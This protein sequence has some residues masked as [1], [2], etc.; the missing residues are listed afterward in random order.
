[1]SVVNKEIKELAA[2]K[3]KNENALNELWGQ[4]K[5]VL[6]PLNED[7]SL[8]TAIVGG[9]VNDEDIPLLRD[10]QVSIVGSTDQY[11]I[12]T[13]KIDNVIPGYQAGEK[14]AI[15]FIT[16]ASGLI[17]AKEVAIEAKKKLIANL[18][19]DL[20]KEIEDDEKIR[21]QEQITS[22]ESDIA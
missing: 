2:E 7:G 12:A 22:I 14:Y 10:D 6:Y 11:R 19:L 16:K 1:M 3:A 17:G 13:I 20:E 9:N 4:I 5:Y 18:E 8:S 15:K 21:I